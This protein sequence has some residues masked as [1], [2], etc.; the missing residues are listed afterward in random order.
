[1][2]ALAVLSLLGLTGCSLLNRGAIKAGGVS[3][4][5]PKDA[6]TPTT[7][8]TATQKGSIRIPA[9]SRII[10]REVAAQ[11]AVPAT[12]ESP[13][14]P[15][16]PALVETE[17]FPS[18]DTEWNESQS[19]VA[20]N[21]G[22]VDTSIASKRIDAEESR[23]L[24]YAAI[25][26]AL[27]AGFFV[28]RAYPTPALCCG[29]ASVVFFMAWRMSGLPSWFWA[30]GLAAIAGGAFLYLGHEKGLYTPVP[31]DSTATKPLTK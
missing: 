29:A 15:A 5:G 2:K 9:N 11:P 24:L 19:T 3:V 8:N 30:L 22:T 25:A 18:A 27:A 26:A 23:P 4:T 20:A 31:D 17:V 16:K 1:M 10:R 7:L 21:S 6:G 12:K 14:I 13:A 28:Y